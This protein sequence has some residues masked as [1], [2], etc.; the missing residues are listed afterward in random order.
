MQHTA[1]HSMA[2]WH[3]TARHGMFGEFTASAC[4]APFEKLVTRCMQV[5]MTNARHSHACVL[6]RLLLLGY[7]C[8]TACSPSN[9]SAHLPDRRP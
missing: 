2:A 5:T 9:T 6:T 3:G 8:C 7:C 4:E 1:Q